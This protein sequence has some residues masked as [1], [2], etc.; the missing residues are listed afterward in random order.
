MKLN[1]K[2]FE[3]PTLKPIKKEVEAYL[4]PPQP[5]SNKFEGGA[6]NYYLE[7]TI[8]PLTARYLIRNFSPLRKAIN[9]MALDV[10]MN[11]IEFYGERA[12]TDEKEE[13][14][15]EQ[16]RKEVDEFWRINLPELYKGGIDYYSYGY[17][18]IEII[19]DDNNNVVGLS[20][21]P[22][23]TCK[24]VRKKFYGKDFYYLQQ[25]INGKTPLFRIFREDYTLPDGTPLPNTDGSLGYVWLIGGDNV[26]KFYS[27]QLWLSSLKYI[28]MGV[29]INDSDMESIKKNNI[30]PGLFA[31]K[32]NFKTT[33]ELSE[34]EITIED[35]VQQGIS[36]AGTGVFMQVFRYDNT[37]KPPELQYV[38]F[39]NTDNE[40]RNTLRT[41]I[42]SDV[43]SCFSIPKERLMIESGRETLNTNKTSTIY[44]IYTEIISREQFR[45]ERDIR[46]FNES[47]FDFKSKVNMLTPKFAE[48][49]NELINAILRLWTSKLAT[50]KEVRQYVR[51]HSSL[52]FGQLDEIGLESQNDTL[53]EADDFPED[54]L[55]Q[56]QLE[57]SIKELELR[58]LELELKEKEYELQEKRIDVETK[59]IDLKA[60][61]S[62]GSDSSFDSDMG[63]EDIDSEIDSIVGGG[64]V[65]DSKSR[66]REDVTPEQV[67]GLVNKKM[68]VKEMASKLDVSQ[69]TILRRMREAGMQETEINSYKGVKPKSKKGKEKD[70]AVKGD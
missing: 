35:E 39:T 45:F 20:Q 58:Q 1:I 11:K 15:W 10:F 61:S 18:P 46:F 47:Y 50:R 48:D 19:T 57:T 44:K 42:E 56:K 64:G 14:K 16:K 24:V 6:N 41:L 34:G 13:T 51:S 67:M 60:S 22:A 38:P 49:T 62:K 12:R 65:D 30:I 17:S 9:V 32:G 37:G 33:E 4:D 23:F 29:S 3:S 31:I 63:V 59:L 36:E 70:N 66:R 8:D 27:E 53:Y 68:Q 26:S 7:P 40:H 5:K 69:A 52:L 25:K 54:T 28:Q 43:I 55:E 21:I 2:K